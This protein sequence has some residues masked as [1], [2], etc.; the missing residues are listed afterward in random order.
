MIHPTAIIDKSAKIDKNVS[1][2]AHVVISGNV[3]IKSGARIDHHSFID[4][5][6]EIGHDVHIHPF[7]S[8]G[9]IPQD[10]K[11]TEGEKSY[12]FVG[13]RTVIREFTAINSGAGIDTPTKIGS[14]CLLMAYAHLG[15]N[16]SIG[17]GVIIA[18]AGTIAGHVE[19]DNNVI[20]GGL[21]G[22]HQ[23]VHIGE[24]AIVGGC[25][26]VV[27]DIPPYMLVDGNPSRVRSINT[28]GLQRKEY[29]KEII[30][31]L[32]DAFKILYKKGLTVSKAKSILQKKLGDTEEVR[33]II[34][35]IDNSERGLTGGKR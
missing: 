16:A 14:D 24:L 11:F 21:T 17:D 1:I 28:I 2:G 5:I 25:S 18:N 26:K 29:P 22:I 13:D 23:F 10:L 32:K 33:K 9:S 35:F 19:I 30:V 20:I 7:A 27:K 12:C 4:C 15:H 34:N 31:K 6:T 3:T 8:V